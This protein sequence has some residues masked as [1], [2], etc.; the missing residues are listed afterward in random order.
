MTLSD[1]ASPS[2][3]SLCTIK[4]IEVKTMLM[5]EEDVNATVLVLGVGNNDAMTMLLAWL[6]FVY[7]CDNV[8]IGGQK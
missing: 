8:E 4:Y 5:A 2:E 3:L 1:V 6:M 7:V